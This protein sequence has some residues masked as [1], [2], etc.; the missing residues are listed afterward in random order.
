MASKLKNGDLIAKPWFKPAFDMVPAT[1]RW[2]IDD[3]MLAKVLDA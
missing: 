3:G 1:S 2:P